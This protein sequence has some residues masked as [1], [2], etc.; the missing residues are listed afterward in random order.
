MCVFGDIWRVLIKII[1]YGLLILFYSLYYPKFS[2]I[3]FYYLLH[4]TKTKAGGVAQMVQ[5]LLCKCKA[6]SSSPSPIKKNKKD[7]KTKQNKTVYI[8]LK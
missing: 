4:K 3:N 5:C 2:I 6:R 1:I 7:L 8:Y